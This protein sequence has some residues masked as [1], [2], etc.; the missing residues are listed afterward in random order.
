MIQKSVL[1]IFPPARQADLARAVAG[2]AGRGGSKQGTQGNSGLEGNVPE[3]QGTR[4]LPTKVGLNKE[5]ESN[6]FYLGEQLSANLMQTTQIKIAQYIESLYGG[7]IMSKLETKIKF[8]TPPPQYP[9]SA[10]LR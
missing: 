3:V 6:I 9:A 2:N 4:A 8:V 10:I 1:R 7:K 5:L